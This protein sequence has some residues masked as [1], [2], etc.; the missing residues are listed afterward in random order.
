MPA[1]NTIGVIVHNYK[2]SAHPIVD[3]NMTTKNIFYTFHKIKLKR[4]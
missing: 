2:V 3:F 4:K 1:T